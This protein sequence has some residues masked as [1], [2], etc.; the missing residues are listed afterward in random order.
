[1][2]RPHRLAALGRRIAPPRFVLFALTLIVAVG[3]LTPLLGRG[4]GVMTGF[5]IAAAVF[6]LAVATLFRGGTT[7]TMRRSARNNDANRTL[8]L[9][10]TAA[11]MLVILVAVHEELGGRADATGR[12]LVIVTLALA[13]LFSNMVFALHYAH[14]FYMPDAQGRDAGGLD[15]PGT[16]AP[17]YWD[18][19][20][21]SYT[22]GMT[23][24]TSDVTVRDGRMRR[25]VLGQSLAG[26]VFNLGVIAF[27]INVLGA[28]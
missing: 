25:V 28:G 17:D 19:L 20:Y 2:Q 24:Q 13:W 4:R 23:F 22:L 10:I 15:V 11:V 7:A 27:S 9:A 21:F 18:F 12:V 16:D 1:M 5:D 26:F 14:L 8:L 3:A 6:L